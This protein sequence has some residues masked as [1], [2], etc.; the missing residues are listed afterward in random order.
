[1]ENLITVYKS[2]YY[3]SWEMTKTE[4]TPPRTVSHFEIEFYTTSG[5]TSVINGVK[6]PQE[7]NNILIAR[8]GDIRY[9]I[10]RFECFCLHF[11]TE[12][13]SITDAI[14]HLPHVFKP[15]AVKKIAEVFQDLTNACSSRATGAQLLVQAKSLELIS[16]LSNEHCE[17][18]AYKY[19]KYSKNIADA[20]E[21]MAKFFDTNIT[22]EDIAKAANLSPGF[23]HSTFKL[24][25]QKTPREYLLQI[26]LSMSKNLLRNTG[27][28]LSEIAFLCG[29]ESQAY[30]SYVFKKETGLSPKKY[31]T[32]Q[33]LI[34]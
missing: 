1:M 31:R 6:Y 33:Q 18:P 5:N 19:S 8:P 16:I 28:S 15:H 29:F 26:R 25:K 24:A 9:S 2:D 22:L 20:C 21:F 3:I 10:D 34:I 27:K 30:F 12:S 32:M 23:F 14:A 4:V 7:K 13:N 17:L 11:S